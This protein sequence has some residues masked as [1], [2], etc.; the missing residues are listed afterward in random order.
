M[1]YQIKL[2]INYEG[3][4]KT[5]SVHVWCQSISTNKPILRS[6]LRM[7]FTMTRKES[8]ERRRHRRYNTEDSGRN[9]KED[10]KG[11]L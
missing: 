8:Q 2:S 7:D 5:F 4:I 3:R 1:L 11:R 9:H 6:P 10:I